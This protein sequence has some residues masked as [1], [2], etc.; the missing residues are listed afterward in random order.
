MARQQDVFNPRHQNIALQTPFDELVDINPFLDQIKPAGLDLI[1]VEKVADKI[2][3]SPTG[4]L[5]PTQPFFLFF[6]NL[7]EQTV[8]H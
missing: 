5:R 6:V 8:L 4:V 1:D 3:D 7:A 2:D